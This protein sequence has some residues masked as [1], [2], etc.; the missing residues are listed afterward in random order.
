MIRIP[1][2]RPVIV[3]REMDYVAAA[4]AGGHASGDGPFTR[5]AQT[6]LEQRYAVQRALLTTSCTAALELAALLCDLG[7]G[8]EVILPSFTFVSTAN[9]VVR[10][11]ATPVFVDIRPDTL[12]IDETRIAAAITPRTRAIFP[13]HYAGIACEMDAIMD[14]AARH[15]LLV[16]ED[17]AQAIESRYKDRYLAT[18]GHLGCFSF[19]ET[20]NVSC[21]EGGA[22]LINDPAL[23]SR[24][25]IVREKGTDRS[26]FLRGQV[27]KYTW[28]DVGSSFLPS[29]MLA[30]YL[31]GQLEHVADITAR[32]GALH[33]RYAS[34]LAPLEAAGHIRLPRTP[35]HRT[36]NHHLFYLLTANLAERSALIG[37]LKE[38][39]IHAVFHYIPLHS[40]PFAR[41]L[42]IPPAVLP[43]TDDT[44][45][46]LVRLPMHLDLTTAD[47]DTVADAVIG[48]YAEQGA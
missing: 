7:P 14:I 2:N 3:G 8:D 33:A 15:D 37:H 6:M 45:D 44:S 30:A 31:T 38:A 39:G 24:A 5:R 23:E 4:V 17:A 12:N 22:L 48:F 11:G 27:D 35:P 36:P 42:G 47:V 28:V 21:G 19:H 16:V 25:E 1:F 20:K 46:R 10:C 32:R 43:V 34:R 18:I 40:A 9:A 26:A 41:S 13:V 29:D